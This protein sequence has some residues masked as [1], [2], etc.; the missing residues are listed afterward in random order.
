MYLTPV[1]CDAGDWP[2]VSIGPVN[3]DFSPCPRLEMHDCR[4]EVGL[5]IYCFQC[6]PKSGLTWRKEYP[7]A[8]GTR[9]GM[10]RIA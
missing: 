4:E 2:P 9:T 8:W 3:P 1:M 5:G 6:W 7:N 10:E